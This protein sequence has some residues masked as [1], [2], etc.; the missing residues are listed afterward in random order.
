MKKIDVCDI[1]TNYIKDYIDYDHL[2]PMAFKILLEII[3]DNNIFVYK[4][5]IYNDTNKTYKCLYYKQLSGLAMGCICGPT[6]ANLFVFLLEKSWLNIYKPIHYSRYIDDIIIISENKINE[7]E[8]KK[9]FNNLTLNIVSG[10]EVNI[11]DLLISVEEDTNKLKFNLYVKPTNT[12]G[13]LLST[14]NH[15]SHIHKNIPKSLFFRLRRICSSYID[16]Q[17]HSRKLIYQL[18]QR[19]YKFNTLTSI[20]RNISNLER[21]SLI[22]YKQKV[23]P[24]TD[25]NKII[26]K[27]DFNKNTIDLKSII[28]NSFIQLKS[29]HDWLIQTNLFL[30][31]LIG[32]N[33]NTIF[34][35]NNSIKPYNFHMKF[36]A[37]IN[38][39][40]CKLKYDSSHFYL[41]DFYFIPIQGNFDCT[42]SNI[43]YIITCTLCNKFY[44]GESGKTAKIRIAQHLYNINSFKPFNNTTEIGFHFNLRGHNLIQHFRFAVIV[45]NIESKE[46]RLSI[47]TDLIYIIERFHGNIINSLKPSTRTIKNNTFL[48]TNNYV[49]TS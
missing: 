37:Q 32:K 10:K 19:G 49:K 29:Q 2:T 7:Q 20:S 47:E 38:C 3:F 46:S 36:C 15:P 17:Y 13:Y 48:N 44:V 21:A 4:K 41:K 23:Q 27:F 16:Y 30:I 22:Q 14:S 26:C 31:N 8:F 9:T 24:L 25:K 6:V 28:N 5:F 33:L 1:I 43:I 40:I 42:A 35:H 34:I 12:F 45:K 11:L 39:K 18:M